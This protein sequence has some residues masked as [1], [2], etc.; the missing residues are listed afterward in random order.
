[1][2]VSRNLSFL[3]G[4]LSFTVDIPLPLQLAAPDVAVEGKLEEGIV[5]D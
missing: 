5:V 2:T 3:V 1:M 4:N